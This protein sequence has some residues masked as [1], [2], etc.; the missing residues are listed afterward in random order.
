MKYYLKLIRIENLL[1]I[2]LSQIVIKYT[3]LNQAEIL[4]ALSDWKYFLLIIATLSIAA[5]GYIINDIYDVDVDNI[6]KPSK[7][8]VG[9]HIS[10]KNAYN[11]YFALNVIGVGLGFYLSRAVGKPAIAATF[12]ICS[13]L[14]YVYSNGLKQIPLVGNAV[15]ATLA[16]FSI[17]VVGLFNI[18]P[19]IFDFNRAEMFNI[20][21][22]I[23]DY[24]V[25]AFLLHFAREII[26]TIEDIEGDKAFE[27]TTVASYFGI[28][29]SKIISSVTLLG[30]IA[31]ACY[32]IYNNI[33]HMP[34]VIGY[35]V[36]L[37]FLPTFFVIVKTILAKE[38][39]DFSFISKLLKFIMLATILSLTAIV[40]IGN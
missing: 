4:Q 28:T 19:F 39:K 34:Y 15:I 5:A 16:S 30:F 37:L 29:I 12:V 26:K 2:A 21:S 35:F 14:L 36:A 9:T 40:L 7:V 1:M 10:E 13:A 11:L 17:L 23:I 3:F 8:Y 25:L 24:A 20:L 38:K 32:F 27:I 33:M 31:Y 6:N 18:Y 22:V